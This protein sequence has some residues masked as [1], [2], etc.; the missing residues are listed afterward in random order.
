MHA[1]SETSS[2]PLSSMT[3][4]A[5]SR[6]EHQVEAVGGMGFGRG[7]TRPSSREITRPHSAAQRRTDTGREWPSRSSFLLKTLC[8]GVMARRG[9]EAATPGKWSGGRGPRRGHRRASAV[10]HPAARSRSRLIKCGQKLDQPD[11]R[12][13]PAGRPIRARNALRQGVPRQAKAGQG[14]AEPWR[15]ADTSRTAPVRGCP[16]M[17]PEIPRRFESLPKSDAS[18]RRAGV[19]ASAGLGLE[20]GQWTHRSIAG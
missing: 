13:I 15:S 14:C 9:G 18:A 1:C 5:R 3:L 11:R 19:G 4:P 8:F 10:I 6:T 12:H 20:S 16:E 7:R 2:L 17:K